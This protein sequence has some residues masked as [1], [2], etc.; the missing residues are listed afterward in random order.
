VVGQGLPLPQDPSRAL[1]R[2]GS[3]HFTPAT[4][5]L[6]D[7]R[8]PLGTPGS[9]RARLIAERGDL[10]EVDVDST[11]G[12][13]LVALDNWHPAWRA[14]VDGVPEAV[15]RADMAFRA[16]RVA[17][18]RHRV[19]FQYTSQAF[20]WGARISVIASGLWIGLL[21]LALGTRRNRP[22]QT[23]EVALS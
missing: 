10:V 12:G 20:A 7:V 6:L 21:V 13:F 14:T 22:G 5:T 18:G 17:P 2:L 19:R 15:L 8:D 16:V 1:A 4:A 11:R 3:T 9:G 23:R